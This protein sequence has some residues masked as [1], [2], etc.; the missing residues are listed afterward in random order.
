MSNYYDR[1]K[2]DLE[3]RA[4]YKSTAWAKCRALV[5]KRDHHLCQD[6]LANKTITK[7][8]TVHHIKEL[9]EYPE[10]AL[11]ASNLV[12]LCNPCHNKRHPEKGQ[13]SAK[14]ERKQRKIRVV[15]T[16]ANPEI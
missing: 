4:F 3:A 16:E 13:K 12:S 9:R 6:C 7:A 5:L 2:R 11:D 15:K 1:H 10:L 14:T 8:E